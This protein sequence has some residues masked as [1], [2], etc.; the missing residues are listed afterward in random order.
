MDAHVSRRIPTMKENTVL[1]LNDCPS[2]GE[3]DKQTHHSKDLPSIPLFWVLKFLYESNN[4]NFFQTNPGFLVFPTI[5]QALGKDPLHYWLDRSIQQGT[6]ERFLIL[7][8]YQLSTRNSG[9]ASNSSYLC[10]VS[11]A[12]TETQHDVAKLCRYSVENLLE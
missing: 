9:I 1:V 10:H 12:V 6:R 3:S 4:S 11:R 8:L 2:C 7:T 5:A